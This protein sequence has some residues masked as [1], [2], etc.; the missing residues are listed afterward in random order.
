[1]VRFVVPLAGAA[2]LWGLQALSASHWMLAYQYADDDTGLAV[3]LARAC[4]EHGMCAAAG[5]PTSGLGLSHGASWIRLIGYCLT[6]DGSLG[7]LQVIVLALLVAGTAVSSIVVW[8]AVSWRAAMFASLF[9]L[10]ATM[11]TLRFDDLTNGTI[12]PLPLALYYACTVWGVQSGRLLPALGAAIALAAAMSTSLSSILLAP[13]LL[14][15]VALTARQPLVTTPLAAVT[16]AA[17]FALESSRAAAQLA[18]LLVVPSMLALGL[19]LVAIGATALFRSGRALLR[20][21]ADTGRARRRRFLALPPLP[22]VRVAMTLAA[23]YLIA[24]GALASMNRLRVPD[25]HYFATAVFPLV[26][27]AADASEALSRRTAASLLVV[28][29]LALGSL[30][31]APLA[32]ALGSV[33]CVI[34]VGFGS[35]LLLARAIRSGG[36]TVSELGARRSSGLAVAGALLVCLMSAPDALIY[37]RTPQ[38][39]PVVT[40]ETMVRRL[41]ASGLTFAELMSGLQGQAPFTLQA[42]IA[43][44]DPEFAIDPP[45]PDAATPALLTTIVDPANAARASD[46][47]VRMDTPSGQPALAIPLASF[48]D[49]AGLRTCYATSC[50]EP[51]DPGRC[52]TRRSQGPVRH[53]RPYFPVDTI[54]VEAPG[55][56]SSLYPAGST[57]CVR[58]FV[59]LRTSG[60][61]EP[62]W[63]RA[64]DL[65][66]LHVRIRAVT[67]V[68]FDGALPGPEV[69]LSNDARA[70]GTVEVEVSAHGVGPEAD[71]L[72]QPPLVEVG[73]A[74]EMLLEPY[75]QGRATLR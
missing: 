9:V 17:T 10:P 66:P 24:A 5:M 47:L 70:T 12:L 19:L 13:L 53:D 59:P 29:V 35:L 32:I 8:Q 38:L 57:W 46:V 40:A 65:W 39:W 21:I 55:D 75:R 3:R 2:A 58:F 20:R 71:W 73:A 25:A 56:R 14:A 51:I 27:L 61:R 30:L 16:V 62:H 63:L 37:P 18:H 68:S 11:A 1:M 72:E 7:T 74:N 42:M 50:D 28:L 44:L 48:L 64:P 49:R 4:L 23:L 69:R 54:D 6:T 15:L 36:G 43:S 22:R 26:F 34:A 33:L 67:G 60:S 31:F 52:T 45:M 41:Y